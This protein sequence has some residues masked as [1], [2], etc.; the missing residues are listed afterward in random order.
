M[1]KTAGPLYEYDCHEGNYGMMN[2]LKG[3][4]AD[5]RAADE[6]AKKGK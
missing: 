5:E 3:A 4:R 1:V 6:A 2:L